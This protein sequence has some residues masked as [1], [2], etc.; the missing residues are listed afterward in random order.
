MRAQFPLALAM[1]I[2]SVVTFGQQDGP[3]QIGF[4]ANLNVG[5]T[6]VNFTN[7]GASGLTKTIFGAADRV[8]P[9]IATQETDNAHA[10]APRTAGGPP[11]N[12]CVNVYTFDPQEEEISCCS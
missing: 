10:F 5:D 9:P 1:P 3:Y 2:L 12:I 8:G 11:L 6:I 4:G 7:D